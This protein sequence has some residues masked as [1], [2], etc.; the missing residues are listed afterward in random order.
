MDRPL[1]GTSDP[2]KH[3][4]Y[5]ALMHDYVAHNEMYLPIIIK[6]GKGAHVWDVTGKEYYDFM[7]AYSCVNQG[8][9]HP[10]IIEALTEQAKK[11]DDFLIC[12]AK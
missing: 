4:H 7:S 2:E 8:H 6:E 12:F 1:S 5:I 10:K 3:A 11:I 9:C